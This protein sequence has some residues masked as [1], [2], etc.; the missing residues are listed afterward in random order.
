MAD[1]LDRARAGDAPLGDARRLDEAPSP[2]EDARA[3]RVAASDLVASCEAAWAA[4]QARHPQ[5]PDAV[6]VL[7]TGVERGRLVK[8]GHWWGGQWRV[9]DEARGEVL[10]AGEALHLPPEAVVEVLLHEAAHGLNA[11]RG[12]RDASRGGRYHNAAFK[13]AAAEVGLRPRRLDPYGWARTELTPAT[14]EA[15]A[16]VIAG[17][18][19]EMRLVRGIPAA[20]GIGLEG[21]RIEGVGLGDAGTE[22]GAPGGAGQGKRPAAECGCDPGRKLRMA[23]SV[24]A[25]GPVICGLCG[26]AF[27]LPGQAELRPA[28][29]GEAGREPESAPGRVGGSV[30]GRDHAVEPEALATAE[31]V[32]PPLGREAARDERGPAQRDDAFD[33]RTIDLP[34]PE[35]AAAPA[36]AMETVPPAVLD[37]TVAEIP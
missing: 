8:L 9:G 14:A 31:M 22:G 29:R 21:G 24:L 18:G 11:A 1:P 37:R 32:D 16:G 15:Y 20:R 28:G 13:A 35:P 23:P 4:I 26:S 36:A 7:G 3:S 17:I 34:P 27:A 6:I 2:D 25:R 5:V 33:L 19:A 30:P 10:L 12:I